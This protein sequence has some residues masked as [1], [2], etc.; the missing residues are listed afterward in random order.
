M[1]TDTSDISDTEIQPDL[2]ID[3]TFSLLIA[4]AE[5][6]GILCLASAL[7]F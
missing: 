6:V 5:V 7:P 3:V 1:D 4:C 2:R